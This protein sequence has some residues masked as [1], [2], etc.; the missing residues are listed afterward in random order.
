MFRQTNRRVFI[1]ASFGVCRERTG[2]L[3]IEI[4]NRAA[5]AQFANQMSPEQTQAVFGRELK[6]KIKKRGER[7][8]FQNYIKSRRAVL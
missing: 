2:K 8:F 1:Y 4:E 7:T 3:R 6:I 5:A